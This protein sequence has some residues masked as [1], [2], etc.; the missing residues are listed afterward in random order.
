MQNVNWQ[1]KKYVNRAG[2]RA[3]SYYVVT[4]DLLV[5]YNLSCKCEKTK[6]GIFFSLKK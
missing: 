1:K 5:F 6:D 3:I 2:G 4:L